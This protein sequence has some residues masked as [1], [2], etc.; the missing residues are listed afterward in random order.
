MK[1]PSLTRIISAEFL[2]ALLTLGLPLTAI[3]ESYTPPAGLGA[4]ARRQSAGTR[5]CVFG[6]PANVIALMPESNVGWTTEAYPR[7]YWYLPINQA[8][9]VEFTLTKAS[10]ATELATADIVYQTRLMLSGDAGIVSVRL[11]E[12]EGIASLAVGERYYWR[13]SLFCSPTSEVGEL[14][15][16]GWIE[17]QVLTAELMAEIESASESEKAALYASNGYWFDALDQ[18][19]KLQAVEPD[20]AELQSSWAEFLDS[21]G[22]SNLVNQPLLDEH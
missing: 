9:F 17:R 10:E 12:S 16:D 3:A 21:V 7:F 22:L 5:G 11:P 13:V 1:V 2:V 6:S 8:S 4:P 19:V 15:V 18:F 20:N 14:Q